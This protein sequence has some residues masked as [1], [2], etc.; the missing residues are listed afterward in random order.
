MYTEKGNMLLQIGALGPHTLSGTGQFGRVIAGRNCVVRRAYVVLSTATTG[1]S[2]TAIVKIRPISGSSS[3]EVTV[4]TLT[5]PNLAAG[6][7]LY[8]DFSGVVVKEGYEICL[9]VTVA[10]GAGAGHVYFLVEEDP[11]TLANLG[12]TASA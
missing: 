8:K 10:A 7:T 6:V 12:M 4:S 9:D 5:I 1:A 2:A 11:E 3:G